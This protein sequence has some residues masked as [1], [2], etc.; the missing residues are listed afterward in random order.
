M[1]LNTVEYFNGPFL[2]KDVIHYRH[3]QD[4]IVKK[5]KDKNNLVILPTGL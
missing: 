1:K 5:C 3:Y 2:K 4:N